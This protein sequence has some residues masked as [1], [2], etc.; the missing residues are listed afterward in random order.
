MSLTGRAGQRSCAAPGAAST[1]STNTDAG[2]SFAVFIGS[3]SQRRI[4][5]RCN[6]MRH[7]LSR[8]PMAEKRS[9]SILSGLKNMLHRDSAKSSEPAPKPSGSAR[10]KAAASAKESAKE[11]PAAAPSDQTSAPEAKSEKK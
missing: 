2:T 11:Q 6:R 1:A 8:A 5:G 9:K 7:N 10:K 3:S 4:P